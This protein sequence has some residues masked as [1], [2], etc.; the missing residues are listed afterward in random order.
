[1]DLQRSLQ[2][3]GDTRFH[4]DQRHAHRSWASR[5][6]STCYAPWEKCA[7]IRWTCAGA[8]S[9]I[10]IGGL[11]PEGLNELRATLSHQS[12]WQCRRRWSPRREPEADGGSSVTRPDTAGCLHTCPVF[13]Q[14]Y[15]GQIDIRIEDHHEPG[16]SRCMPLEAHR[17]M[18]L[19]SEWRQSP[20]H[21]PSVSKG[22]QLPYWFVRTTSYH[23]RSGTANMAIMFILDTAH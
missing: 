10:W 13:T 8:D 1:M 16:T 15:A 5:I 12:S 3:V 2:P 22:L 23:N 20:R 17:S 6:L 9:D 4:L 19:A 7:G 14:V 21:N 11:R 18:K